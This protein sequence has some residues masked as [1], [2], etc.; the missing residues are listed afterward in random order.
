MQMIHHAISEIWALRW[1]FLGVASL[2][3]TGIFLTWID[4]RF[5]AGKMQRKFDRD[6]EETSEEEKAHITS[7]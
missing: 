3:C 6:W 2:V 7:W 1:P 5:L 4:N